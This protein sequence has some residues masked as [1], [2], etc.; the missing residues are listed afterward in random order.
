MHLDLGAELAPAVEELATVDQ[1]AVAR[2]HDSVE[3]D[4][5]VTAPCY[6]RLAYT[7]FPALEVLVNNRPVEPL[8]TAAG[9]ICLPLETGN[10]KIV[11]QARLSPLRQVLLGVDLVL[12]AIGLGAFI[13][14]KKNGASLST[15]YE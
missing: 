6:A 3:L 14:S 4:L 10:N 8:R 9:F 13:R 7:Y 2:L 12:L 1:D 11:L 15:R 5:R